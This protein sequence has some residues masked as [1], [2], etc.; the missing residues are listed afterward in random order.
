MAA[1]TGAEI[2]VADMTWL[3]PSVAAATVS[4]TVEPSLAV[5][6]K[7][8]VSGTNVVPTRMTLMVSWESVRWL[9]GCSLMSVW[10]IPVIA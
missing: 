10:T 3:V 7:P 8:S 1:A 6:S 2:V 4:A 9:R 5:G